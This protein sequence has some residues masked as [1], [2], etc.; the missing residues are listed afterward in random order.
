MRPELVEGRGFHD[1]ICRPTRRCV[2]LALANPWVGQVWGE[3]IWIRNRGPQGSSGWEDW[4]G[5]TVPGWS[6]GRA[7][8]TL[9]QD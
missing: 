1:R 3:A 2:R 4:P 5:P 7:R 8:L 9:N 6:V